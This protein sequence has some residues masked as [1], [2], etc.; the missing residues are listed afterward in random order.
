M[1]IV[2][3]KLFGLFFKINFIAYITFWTNLQVN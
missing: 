3:L 1:E 2:F